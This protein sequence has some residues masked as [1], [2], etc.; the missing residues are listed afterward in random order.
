M[1]SPSSIGCVAI[2]RG[3]VTTSLLTEKIIE[4]K[5]GGIDNVM[6]HRYI[7]LMTLKHLIPLCT[8]G[9]SFSTI[10]NAVNIPMAGDENHAAVTET[11]AERDARMQ[12]W[13]DAKFGMFIHWGLYS[14]LAGEWKGQ[15]GGAEW[16]QK[17]MEL[18]TEEYAAEAM[19]LFRPK[20]NFAEK[21]AQLAKEAGCQYAVL[22]SKHH[23][24]FALFDTQTGD[25]NAKK[26]TGRDLI[27]EYTDAMHKNG[28]RVGFYHSV[29]DWHNSDYD[30]TI[31]PGLCY[32]KRQKFML[33]ERGV[34]RNQQAY[35]QYLHSQVRELL[36][37]YGKIDIIWWDYSQGAAE[38]KRAWDAPKLINM[39]RELQPG[40][41][42]NNRLYAYA[43]LKEDDANITLDV[44]KGDFLTPERR[45][46]KNGYLNTDWEACMTVSDKWGYTRYDTKI[47]SP[48]ELIMKLA[49]CTAKGGNLL[50]NVNPNA[51]G[52]I[53]EG[54]ATA[55][56]NVG[57]WLKTNGEAIYGTK[58]GFDIPLP[59][60]VYA[61]RKKDAVYIIF[62]PRSANKSGDTLVKIPMQVLG[63]A[64]S[65]QLLSEGTAS[66]SLTAEGDSAVLALPAEVWAKHRIPVVKIHLGN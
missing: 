51:S 8:L 53:P 60:G 57:E 11:Q 35:Q 29:I 34:P 2:L 52:D 38:G 24:G 45:I 13:R 48:E 59:E 31:C 61:T 40:I 56:R 42:M 27:R 16:I 7:F 50:L 21:W 22:T 23:E 64:K 4:S 39:C 41:I 30:Y 14:G 12:W 62:P 25:Y 5:S 32:P 44:R 18:N 6:R 43:G 20:E 55:M 10:A 17:N 66:V 15:P 28:I 3:I 58:P 54:V 63:K 1:E 36:S 19:P 9:I 37:N 49:E 46:P 47:K 26:L 33:E 65:V